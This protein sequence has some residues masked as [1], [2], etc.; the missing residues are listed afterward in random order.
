MLAT[1]SWPFYLL[2]CLLVLLLLRVLRVADAASSTP[3]APTETP[4]RSPIGWFRARK[5]DKLASTTALSRA[6]TE[7]FHSKI[8][9]IQAYHDLQRLVAELQ[10]AGVARP[11]QQTGAPPTNRAALTLS[12]IQDLLTVLNLEEDTRADVLRLAA[13]RLAEKRS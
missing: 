1:D 7:L 11:S 5:L 9:E 4:T 12:E 2:A 13:A 3:R 10:P 6:H 8:D